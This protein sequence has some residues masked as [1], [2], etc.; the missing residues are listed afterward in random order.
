MPN[1]RDVLHDAQFQD[2]IAVFIAFFLGVAMPLRASGV[3]AQQAA[4]GL[5]LTA[6]LIVLSI[7]P[8]ARSL[9][10]KALF[11][12]LGGTIGLVFVAWGVGLF[13]SLDPYAS[14]KVYIRTGVFVVAAVLIWAVLSTHPKVHG[15]MWKSLIVSSIVFAGFALLS[16][17]GVPMILSVL[18]GHKLAHE[19]PYQAFKAFAATVMCL[20]PMVVW[21]GRK[22]GGAW[23]WA[24]YIFVPMAVVIMIQT[25]NRAALA[26]MVIMAAFL[27]VR[28]LTVRN[29]Y[30][31]PTLLLTLSFVVSALSWVILKEIENERQMELVGIASNAHLYLPEWLV[32]DHRQYI[33]KFVFERFVENP[34]LGNGIDQ[35][36][37]LPNAELRIPYMEGPAQWVPSHPHNWA[38]E[39]LA[40]TGVV[41]FVPM[42]VALGLTAWTLFRRYQR[43]QDEG[44]FALIVFMAGFWLSALFNFSIWATWWQL[45]F[46]VLFAMLASVY[47]EKPVTSQNI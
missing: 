39:V 42:I 8:T 2:R 37:K 41:G 18:K 46:V 29:K 31:I 23:Q 26:G 27:A 45:T 19:V 14:L 4:M 44:V 1:F 34:W 35:I 7:T 9:V 10:R 43:R 28:V 40:E 47:K 25:F 32:D 38:L 5:A 15:I 13:F 3:A 22:Y 36:N 33:W 20:V 24:G 17:N 12:K 6:V 21:A 30:V 16:I 11:S